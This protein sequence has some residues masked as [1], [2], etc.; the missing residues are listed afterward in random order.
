MKSFLLTSLLFFAE[1][2]TL[3]QNFNEIFKFYRAQSG[4]VLL[5]EE[6][7]LKLFD[8][9]NL[10]N[11]DGELIYEKNKEKYD[12][13][14][15]YQKYGNYIVISYL[16]SE[17]CHLLPNPYFCSKDYIEFFNIEFSSKIYKLHLDYWSIEKIDDKYIFLSK[18]SEL[19]Q[20]DLNSL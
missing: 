17:G 18:N 5:N 2:T 15:I 12:I 16:E 7:N 1:Y 10:Y 13:T 6:L 20:I 14:V 4:E 3:A 8:N 19:R 9:G 11:F